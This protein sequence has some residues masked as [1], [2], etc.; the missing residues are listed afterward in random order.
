MMA[1]EAIERGSKRS[2]F[3]LL[4]SREEKCLEHKEISVSD[5]KHPKY[6][7]EASNA[8]IAKAAGA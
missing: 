8:W 5:W 4:D 1:S 3:Y 2:G 6:V 7:A